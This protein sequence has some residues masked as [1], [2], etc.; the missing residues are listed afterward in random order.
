M[1][2]QIIYS[3]DQ[4]FIWIKTMMLLKLNETTETMS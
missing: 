3:A 1:G 2:Y 4:S